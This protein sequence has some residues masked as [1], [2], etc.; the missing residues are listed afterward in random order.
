MRHEKQLAILD[1]LL[2]KLES[3]TTC[4]TGTQLLNPA[5]AYIDRTLAERE[6]QVLFREHP[7]L[8]GLSGDLPRPGSFVAVEDFGLPLLA[9]RDRE[10]VFHA[11]LNACRHR[12]TQ[13]THEPR[14]E[15]QRFTCPFHGW[16]YDVNGRLVGITE[17]NHFGAP[18]AGCSSLIELPAVERHGMLWV[19]PQPGATLD[20]DALLGDFAEELAGYNFG[21]LVFRGGRHLENRMNWKLAND[22]FGETYHFSRLHRDTVNNIFHGDLIACESAGRNHRMVFPNRS[23]AK[24]RKKPRDAWHLAEACSV[25]YYFFPNIQFVVTGRHSTMFRIYP[26]GNDPSRSRTR[27]SHY[28]SAEALEH[29]ARGDKT[30]IDETNVYNPDARDG[31]AVVAPEASIEIV[32]STV[33]NEDYR[34]AESTQRA[35]ES[36]LVDHLVFGRNEGPLHH[37]HQHLREVLQLPPLSSPQG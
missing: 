32:D 16:T 4:D 3:G 37:F 2:D 20:V 33:E 13:L 25:L 23:L 27:M 14:G 26:E 12:G 7:Q 5:A 15:A 31:N 24:L 36:G 9:T 6:W 34:I 19:H 10:G 8:I 30:V 22:S 11:F 17:S 21:E 29:L 35:L 28:F 1:E 18:P